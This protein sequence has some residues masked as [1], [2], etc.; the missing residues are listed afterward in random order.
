MMKEIRNGLIVVAT[1]SLALIVIS[2]RALVVHGY[3]AQIGRPMFH[4]PA[5]F[6]FPIACV[7][8]GG[9]A[10][11]LAIMVVVKVVRNRRGTGAEQANPAYRR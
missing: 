9:A 3:E 11:T 6:A 8:G 5:L 1:L 4:F 7:A 10:V 2:G